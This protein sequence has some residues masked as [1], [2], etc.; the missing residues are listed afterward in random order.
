[1]RVG[2]ALGSN[3]GDRLKALTSA[4][5]A[6]LK[7]E[8]VCE[9]ALS[10][11]I[12]ET[13]PV[14]S[15]PDSSCFL[16]AVVEVEFDGDPSEL[17]KTLQDL[18]AEM[19]RPYQRPRNAPRVIDLD[20]LYM[21][22]LKFSLPNLLIPHPRLHLRRF[23]LEPLAEICPMLILPEQSQNVQQTLAKLSDPAGVRFANLQ[24]K[25]L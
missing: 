19:G 18:E 1:M 25:P 9:P 23:V 4:R 15:A 7:L 2:I 24:W 22:D 13:D 6:I 3:I 11:S 5:E 14:D 21:G 8:G 10:S 17:L 20:I 16:N 12:Y